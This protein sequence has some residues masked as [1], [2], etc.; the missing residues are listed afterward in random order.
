MLTTFED[1]VN[2]CL[3]TGKRFHLLYVYMQIASAPVSDT[4]RETLF[5]G[6]DLAGIESLGT[7][8]F[9]AHEPIRPGLTFEA[10]RKNADNYFPDWD[11]VFVMTARNA[12]DSP[13]DDDQAKDFLADMR[14][15]IMTG[16]FPEWAPIFD[17]TGTLKGI[18]RA[19]PVD[20]GDG[21]R[22]PN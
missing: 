16:N 7:I 21:E 3:E 14:E 19:H 22:R 1:L 12:D 18:D 2:G 5:P 10:M 13:V 4:A 15:R 9:D 6:Q 20:L 17:R 11:V 8:A